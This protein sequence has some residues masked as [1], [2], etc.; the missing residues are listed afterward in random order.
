MLLLAQAPE[1]EWGIP[2][3]LLAL[4]QDAWIRTTQRVT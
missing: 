3:E 4:A 2:E 1:G